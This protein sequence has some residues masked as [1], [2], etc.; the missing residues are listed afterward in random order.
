MET[1]KKNLFTHAD[2]NIAIREMKSM[3]S[4]LHKT[5]AML[6]QSV[7]LMNSIQMGVGNIS[8]NLVDTSTMYDHYESKL[9][10]TDLYVKELKKKE[11]ENARKIK[12]S[13]WTLIVVV[14]FIFIRRLI[15]P[16]FYRN[17]FK[18]F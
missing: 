7:D 13:F 9:K 4:H 11:E 16:S 15:F 17:F 6:H 10:K 5:K 2:P 3:H 8:N 14:I 18:I 1:S 12:I